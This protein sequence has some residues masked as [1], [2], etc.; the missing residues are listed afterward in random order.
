MKAVKKILSFLMVGV[1]VLGNLMPSGVH[2]V[3][4]EHTPAEDAILAELIASIDCSNEKVGD[5]VEIYLDEVTMETVDVA[6]KIMDAAEGNTDAAY[7]MLEDVI[8]SAD[9]QLKEGF[10]TSADAAQLMTELAGAEL[11]AQELADKASAELEAARIALEV[12]EAE[13][14]AAVAVSEEAAAAAAAQLELAKEAYTLAADAAA[15]AG[16]KLAVLRGVIDSADA[17]VEEWKAAN[18]EAL[19][20]AEA[21]LEENN[22]VLKDALETLEAEN[23]ELVVAIEAFQ[24]QTE[25]LVD[26]IHAFVAA[27]EDAKAK[28][29]A[30]EGLYAEYEEVLVAYEVAL[31]AFATEHALETVTYEEAVTLMSGLEANINAAKEAVTAAQTDIDNARAEIDRIQN[32]I[33]GEDNAWA[34]GYGS[35]EELAY[36]ATLNSYIAILNNVAETEEKKTNAAYEIARLVIEKQLANG[37]TVVWN[38]A[39]GQYGKSENGF[40]VV[41]DGETVT[42][43]Y[44]YLVEGEEHKVVNIYTMQADDVTNYVTYN[45]VEYVLEGE[46]GNYFITIEGASVAVDTRVNNGTVEY[47]VTERWFEDR[48][49]VYESQKVLNYDAEPSVL[50]IHYDLL[51]YSGELGLDGFVK[52]NEDCYESVI[53][54][55][56]FEVLKIVVTRNLE[57]PSKWVAEYYTKDESV[58]TKQ[59]TKTKIKI[60]WSGITTEIVSASHTDIDKRE[61]CDYVFVASGNYI[62][63]VDVTYPEKTQLKYND[64]WYDLLEDEN[65][66]YL[67]IEG[68]RVSIERYYE[69]LTA[70]YRHN[71][72][73]LCSEDV[74]LVYRAG[75]TAD[76]TFVIGNYTGINSETYALLKAE[77]WATYQANLAL[78]TEMLKTAQG[79]EAEALLHHAQMLEE[80]AAAEAEYAKAE[81][82]FLALVAAKEN[83]D[84]KD[85]GMLANLPKDFDDLYQNSNIESLEDVAKVMEAIGIITK[86]VD[87]LDFDAQAEKLEAYNTLVQYFALD[88]MVFDADYENMNILE[89]FKFWS[90]FLIGDLGKALFEEESFQHAYLMAW[91]DAT[92]AKLTV[93]TTGMKVVEEASATI[94]SG[95][96]V[97]YEAADVKDAVI[98]AMIAQIENEILS[99]TVA[100]LVVAGDIL[101]A[102]D[103]ILAALDAKV[104]ALEAEINAA[105][106]QLRESAD[107]LANMEIE[108]PGSEELKEA[109]AALEDAQARYDELAKELADTEDAIKDAEAYRAEAEKQ[110]EELYAF[111]NHEHTYDV[112]VFEATCEENG[113][114]V[115]S[116]NYK[117]CDHE[118]EEVI[119]AFGHLY[120][121]VVTLPGCETEGSKVHTCVHCGDVITE[122]IAAIGHEYKDVV[123]DATCEEDGYKES[124][125][126]H[127]GDV[128]REEY[129]AT[130]HKFVTEVVNP[131]CEVNGYVL[132]T[133]EHCGEYTFEILVATGHEYGVVITP[134]TCT[135]AGSKVSTCAHCGDVIIE[136][137]AATGHNHE[138]V[139]VNPTCEEDGSITTTC[140]ECDY[141]EVVVLSATGHNHET[142]TTEATCTEDGSIVTT[143]TECSYMDVVVLEALGHDHVVTTTEASCEEDGSIVT[144]CTRCDY[145]EVETI[146]AT[147]HSNET[148]VTEATCEECGSIVTTCTIC[149]KTE[150]EVL[151]ANG[152]T[153]EVVTVEAT[154]TEDGSITTTCTDCDFVTV[155]VIPA[156]GHNHE[157]ITVE[158]TCTEDGSI[159]TT[160]T[161]CDYEEVEVIEATGHSWVETERLE[162]SEGVEGY[163]NY[164]CEHCDE[165]YT[166]TLEALPVVP[167][168]EEE[169]EEESEEEESEEEESEEEESEEEESEEEESE[170][171]ESE[172]GT[173]IQDEET[174]KTDGTTDIEDEE[175]P[176]APGEE[177]DVNQAAVIAVTTSVCAVTVA[178]VGYA[179]VKM[180]WLSVFF[181]K[182]FKM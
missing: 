37:L 179:G 107:A 73:V 149:G 35:E 152:H 69:G 63:N 154:C 99:G 145:N 103:M 133:C 105:E 82:T 164:A 8:A 24:T 94:T 130:G 163:I 43:R 90:E 161:N 182:I 22:V 112:T 12:A 93:V 56:S 167:E 23:T 116:C 168:E 91:I 129:E 174:P 44:G 26:S 10:T 68:N 148:V 19:A 141:V 89:K 177:K 57:D 118:Y 125:C 3:S 65:G 72:Q 108:N 5:V 20:K 100:A 51:G 64:T 48:A 7:G 113:K 172:E 50:Q 53:K 14:L 60:S 98:E 71:Y 29:E 110:Y 143:C 97:I 33:D 40:F 66:F 70:N 45:G 123:V 156:T 124:T 16:E 49:D 11:A 132:T 169:T 77:A 87:A 85:L 101:D 75:G 135:E 140:T 6:Q 138:V 157:T 84:E 36:E 30:L 104:A 88:D 117:G 79:V 120:D 74:V 25:E 106:A 32:L 95:L 175:T 128:I 17:Y 80:L 181:R 96:E 170:E 134:A 83:Y 173:D 81:A 9:T 147:G 121:T 178:A 47:Y 31:A 41:L 142:V 76:T 162:A 127:C 159:T 122:G 42:A 46:A 171:E 150:T 28:Q 126:L 54:V 58:C 139:T 86:D 21:A 165:V 114:F 59:H 153:H 115:Y 55:A 1:L 137:I 160:C 38:E 61:Q 119:E 78:Y 180:G 144:I 109:K 146:P 158:A 67:E 34:N 2:A 39:D 27:I 62:E 92:Y 13:Y 176:L 166:E 4:H 52:V 151:D 131:T 18:D 111:E 15:F 136:E 155:D 102:S